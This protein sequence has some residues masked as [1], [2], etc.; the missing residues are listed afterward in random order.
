EGGP[1]STMT[2]AMKP[3]ALNPGEDEIVI[4]MPLWAQM[5][6]GRLSS[7][8]QIMASPMSPSGYAPP[9]G[10][11]TLVA[12][13]GTPLDF[14]GG[15]GPGGKGVTQLSGPTTLELAISGGLDRGVS[16]SMASGGGRH[17]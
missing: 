7:T 12:P 14:T 13:P 8:D 1:I 2:E 16:A 5:G 17:L 15:A 9:L 4:P 6:R 11:Y 10:S 3:R